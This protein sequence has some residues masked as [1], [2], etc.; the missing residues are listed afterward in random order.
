[1]RSPLSLET[2]GRK[3]FGARTII[4]NRCYRASDKNQKSE[5]GEAGSRRSRRGLGALVGNELHLAAFVYRT[6][7]PPSPSPS[8]R[9]FKAP[10][11]KKRGAFVVFADV[12]F[13]TQRQNSFTS[14]NNVRNRPFRQ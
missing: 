9:R 5:C 1:L 12:F 14:G 13:L 3:H 7:T 2:P 11:P 6:A 10:R 4:R 8:C